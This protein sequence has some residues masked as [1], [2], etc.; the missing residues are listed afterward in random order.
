MIKKRVLG[1]ILAVSLSISGGST[2]VMAESET[3]T[4][5]EKVS[6]SDQQSNAIEMLNY[7][8]VL[9]QEI[10]SSK[11]SRLYLEEAYSTLINNIFPNA[12]DNRTLNQLT[13]LLDTM[14]NYRMLNVKRD[15]LKYIYD[16][17][18]AQAIKAAVPNPLG[19]ISAVHSF[20]PSKLVAS[21][22]YMAV[23]SYTSYTAYSNKTE[24]E[25]I[26]EGW[27]LDDE[28]ATTLHE[29]R[30]GTF[31]Y[32]VNMVGEYNL[33]G[34]VA[35][36]EGAV[37]E[38]VDWKNNE[39]IV[40]RIQFLE[41]NQKTYQYFGG[42]WLLLADSYYNN[43]DYE[44]CLNAISSYEKVN[45]RI[46]RK[47]YE[48]A[49][50]MPA[51]IAAAD[52]VYDG[53]TYIDYVEKHIQT[54]IDNTDY[55]DWALRYFAA[56]T[57]IDLFGQTNDEKYLQ[58]AYALVLDNVNYLVNEQIEL[59]NNYLAPIQEIKE[60][61]KEDKDQVK[62]YNKLLKE[63]RKTA[64]PQVY[65]PLKVNC[66]LL[67]ALAEE[68]N[69][70]DE[71]KNKIDNLLHPSG[72]SL[73]LNSALDQKYWF[74]SEPDEN[75]EKK[76]GLEIEYGGNGMILPVPVLT[77]Q[78]EITVSI[79]EKDS[80]DLTVIEDW[81]IEKVEREIENDVSTFEAAYT[82]KEAKKYSWKEGETITIDINPTGDEDI[83]TYHYEYKTKGTK[84]KWYDYLKVWEGHRNN[85]YEYAKVWEN[86]VEFE[87][88]K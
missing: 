83:E 14:E 46:F 45:Y 24:L 86:S 9:T 65:E 2:A 48:L 55:S 74:N 69:I 71:E 23:D 20:R 63:E 28:E 21:I 68:M 27:A 87:R 50:I 88:V 52:E 70:S 19:I 64:L 31:S 36:T 33:P 11:N 61:N 62:K 57:L 25:Y 84:N 80:D 78:A 38:F 5:E 54:I 29:C 73:F 16:Q 81:E 44:K 4:E 58:Q 40:G 22:A 15:R 79:K 34:D 41:S 35:L 37:E 26:K 6:L 3:Y 75:Q 77:E 76:E 1:I 49:K 53:Q 82:S 51:V 7:I 56:Q 30:K 67:F 10:N 18:Q 12:V 17:N 66:D 8:T 32:M 39:N 47:D 43:G 72:S 13:G 60:S 59:N 42:Y 85:W